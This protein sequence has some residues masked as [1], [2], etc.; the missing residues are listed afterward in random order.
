MGLSNAV[1]PIVEAQEDETGKPRPVTGGLYGTANSYRQ[2]SV[3]TNGCICAI[4]LL[5][6]RSDFHNAEVKTMLID[7]GAP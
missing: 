5:Q 7:D 1:D 4:I 2:F 6:C 3:L